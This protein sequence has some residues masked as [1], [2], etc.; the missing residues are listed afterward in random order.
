MLMIGIKLHHSRV[1]YVVEIR[2]QV[3][4]TK[5]LPQQLSILN[6]LT[7]TFKKLARSFPRR[8][9]DIYRKIKSIISEYQCL[10][11]LVLRNFDDMTRTVIPITKTTILEH[12][13][14]LTWIAQRTRSEIMTL[15][16]LVASVCTKKHWNSKLN[17]WIFSL[18]VALEPPF[19]P[20]LCHDLRTI[21][22]RCRK[23]R[24]DFEQS[25]FPT[26]TDN[27]VKQCSVVA[28]DIEFFNLC[29][30]LI[31]HTFGQS[32]LADELTD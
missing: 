23:L 27:N 1:C 31:S 16:N 8:F 14:S 29:I 25:S 19:H 12:T 24:R 13:P 20:D 5:R 22:K 30:N 6:R 4:S 7:M 32:D 26:T 17:V 21:V 9:Q 2:L 18:L 28:E 3:W 10:K 11:S 15:I